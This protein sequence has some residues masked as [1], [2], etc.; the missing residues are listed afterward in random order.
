VIRF[1]SVKTWQQ[2]LFVFENPVLYFLFHT[3]EPSAQT[4]T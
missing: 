3:T 2:I 1:T 4:G